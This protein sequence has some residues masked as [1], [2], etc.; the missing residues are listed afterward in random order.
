MKE[1][2]SPPCPPAW[3][4][5]F[6]PGWGWS[7]CPPSLSSGFHHPVRWQLVPWSVFPED[8]SPVKT[9]I[10]CQPR[11]LSTLRAT[12]HRVLGTLALTCTSRFPLTARSW[13][14]ICLRQSFL[15]PRLWASRRTVPSSPPHSLFMSRT[16]LGSVDGC[17]ERSLMLAGSQRGQVEG[18]RARLTLGQGLCSV[19]AHS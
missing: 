18:T 13:H 4:L 9:R 16:P 7:F 17:S 1:L 3:G 19:G 2:A 14:V 15:C 8:H 11:F 6:P 5:L 10:P 12:R